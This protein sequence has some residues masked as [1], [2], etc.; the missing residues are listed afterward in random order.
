M[1]IRKLKVGLV[2]LLASLGGAATFGLFSAGTAVGN[3]IQVKDP[4]TTN[5]PYLAWAG[6]QV[7]MVKCFDAPS[8][9]ATTARTF[10]FS[11]VRAEF[12]VEDWS[13]DPNFKPQI[14]DP[15]VKLFF[16]YNRDQVCA[17]GDAIALDPGLARIELDV[18][19]NAGVLGLPSLGGP[20]DPVLKHQFLAGWMTLNDPSLTE[21]GASDFAASAQSAASSALGDPKGDGHF[22]PGNK[23]GILS[24]KVSGSIPMTGKWATLIG[25][26]SVTLP[27][28]WATLAGALATDQNPADSNPAMRWDI[29]DNQAADEGHVLGSDCGGG[30]LSGTDAV[31]NCTGGGPDGPFSRVFGDLTTDTAVGPFDPLR[32]NDTL[33]SNGVLDSGDAPMPAARIDVSIKQNTGGASDI[34]GVGYLAPQDKAVSYSRDFTGAPTPHNLFAPFYDAFIPATAAHSDAASGIDGPAT[35][36]DFTG[37]LNADPYYRFW[38]LAYTFASNS[39]GPT[40]CLQR[41]SDPQDDSPAQNPGD[42]YQTPSGPSSVAVYTD[43]QGEA[44]VQYVPGTGFYFNSL[45]NSGKAITNANGGCDLQNVGLLGTADITAVA[46]YPYKPVDYPAMT[47]NTVHKDVKSLWSKTLTLYPKGTGSANNNARIVVAHAQ[48]IDGSPFVHE[49]VCF[50]ADAESLIWFHGTIKGINL[51]GT[52]LGQDPGGGNRLCVVTDDNGNAGIEV[53]ESKP[54]HVDVIADFTNEGILRNIDPDFSLPPVQVGPV[55]N[56]PSHQACRTLDCGSPGSPH[57]TPASISYARLGSPRHGKAILKVKV[58]STG[59]RAKI[60]IRLTQV[61]VSRDRA[62]RHVRMVRHYRTI[63]RTVRTNRVVKITVPGSA[64]AASV[65][66]VK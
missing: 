39:G 36:N 65:R 42:Y 43:E 55:H 62:G 64:V 63:T 40:S 56:P 35:G 54:I 44:Q 28:D 10:D 52:S 9:D 49:T 58:A 30:T 14:E 41:S 34:S 31:D 19:D 1:R 50:S 23:P 60:R 7:R 13:G 32:Q 25:K 21:L 53:L 37:F 66:L 51:N 46:R 45:I 57:H 27:D 33:L 4:Q 59:V 20:A 26:S 18:T 2:S 22:T 12:L 3:P 5:V 16:S 38:D 6:E 29:H 11:L 48:D 47:S 24:V 8:V 61:T 17:Q 15:T